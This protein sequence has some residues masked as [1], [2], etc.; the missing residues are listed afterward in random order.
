[1]LWN[2]K[3][4]FLIVAA[5]APKKKMDLC[6]YI[7][8]CNLFLW[9]KASSVSYDLSEIILIC[10]FAEQETFIIII[11]IINVENSCAA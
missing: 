8:K 4:L 9:C 6:I 5:F 7:L 10:W 3:Y 1:M 11:I 2:I